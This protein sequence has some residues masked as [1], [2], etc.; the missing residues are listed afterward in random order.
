MNIFFKG[1]RYIELYFDSPRHASLNNQQSKTN[2]SSHRPSPP[3][4]PKTRR[5][6]RSST[7]R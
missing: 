4:K 7:N 6:S 3:S 1:G 2:G 5:D